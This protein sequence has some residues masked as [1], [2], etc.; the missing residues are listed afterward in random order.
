VGGWP[1]LLVDGES[2]AARADSLE[3]TF[4]RFSTTRHPRSGI[5]FSRDSTTLYLITVD[6]RQES[7]D[8]MS[9]VEFAEEMKRDGV[10]NGLNLDGGGSTTLVIRGRLANKP[11]DPSGERAVGNAILIVEGRR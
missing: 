2:V 1:R 8:G 3:G 6:G 4:P 5:G 7:S 10:W 11:S 9:L